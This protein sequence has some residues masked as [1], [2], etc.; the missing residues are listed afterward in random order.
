MT[1][2]RTQG[3]PA[4]AAEFASRASLAGATSYHVYSASDIVN[5]YHAGL[6]N[7]VLV[8]DPVGFSRQFNLKGLVG[9][10]PFNEHP[11]EVLLAHDRSVIQ[12]HFDSITLLPQNRVWDTNYGWV[13][14]VS[15]GL[16]L[17]SSASRN[18]RVCSWSFR[19]RPISASTQETVF[20]VG[21]ISCD[22]VGTSLL[23]YI[24]L[25]SG[26]R[27]SVATLTLTPEQFN[28]VSC[29]QDGPT[30]YIGVNNVEEAAPVDLDY[31][32]ISNVIVV[33][34]SAAYFL[35]SDLKLWNV[36]KTLDELVSVNDYPKAPTNVPFLP[37]FFRSAGKSEKWAFQ[38][39]Q[40]GFCYPV[41]VD[42]VSW[43]P[44]AVIQRYTEEGRYFGDNRFKEVGLGGGQ[45][46]PQSFQFGMRFYEF[47][48]D[49]QAIVSTT[50]SN[51]PGNNALW[52]QQ[53]PVPV[54]I[55]SSSISIDSSI[56]TIDSSGTVVP[57]IPLP[58]EATNP[59]RDRMTVRGVDGFTYEAFID[60]VGLGPFFRARKI[61][62]FRVPP[63]TQGFLE[64]QDLPTGPLVESTV[65]TLELMWDEENGDMV[66]GPG[67]VPFERPP[68]YLYTQS[69]R[70]IKQFGTQ[71]W[72]DPTPE[73]LEIGSPFRH[74]I[75][76]FSFLN[77]GTLV[78]GPHQLN[79]DASVVGH[80]DKDFPGF[81]LQIS[82]GNSEFPAK[83]L[84]N[85]D[86][87][88]SRRTDSIEFFV[89]TPLVGKWVTRID[90]INNLDTPSQGISR[91][92]KIHGYEIRYIQPNVYQVVSNDTIIESPITYS[93][94]GTLPPGGWIASLN[95][96]G[97]YNEWR[98]EADP[99]TRPAIESY[100]STSTLSNVLTGATTNKHEDVILLE[101][102]G[103]IVEP[104]SP[105]ASIATAT[106]QSFVGESETV[107]WIAVGKVT[108]TTARIKAK[109][110]TTLTPLTLRYSTT[111]GLSS[112]V[113]TQHVWPNDHQIVTF[114]LS[115]LAENTQ[116]YFALGGIAQPDTTMIGSFRTFPVGAGSFTFAASS[117]AL[118]GSTSTI[119][120]T[121][122]EQ[123]PLF[124]LHLGNLHTQDVGID[125]EAL[126]RAAYELTYTAQ[127]QE[128]L[129]RT[130]P[131]VYTWDD[132]DFGDDSST[133]AAPAAEAVYREYVPSYYLHAGNS[134]IYHSFA[135]GRV[136]FIIL[137]TR[138]EK[139]GSTLLGSPQ[140]TWLKRQLVDAKEDYDLI[141]IC[142]ST[143]WI[144]NDG[145]DPSDRD[146]S[147]Y[148][149]VDTW[150]EYPVERRE[151]AD[152]MVDNRIDNVAMIC[153]GM[154]ALAADDGT[155]SDYST[156]QTM[157]MPV[158]QVGPLDYTSNQ[159][160]GPYTEGPYPTTATTAHQFGLF[161]VTD[162][163]NSITLA[164]SGRDETNEEQISLSMTV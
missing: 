90:W 30:F 104:Q 8:A 145:V 53:A 24:D 45:I 160:G 1:T 48:A 3:Q 91:D 83:I 97:E 164:F 126:F 54:T 130:R 63:G 13:Y 138:S 120:S 129:Y 94:L 112:V 125:S 65:G 16:V 71:N 86:A 99:L 124:F 12:S 131:Y 134:A 51:L 37:T 56:T 136:F 156:S 25:I 162:N 20:R 32:P 82:V 157:T 105:S 66:L 106:F 78:E 122:V 55:D 52:D 154:K 81:D 59:I 42:S 22:L 67:T 31:G 62:R 113:E 49:G 41:V 108:S 23:V 47:S 33:K 17:T 118:T 92:L 141:I 40:Q 5:L 14:K 46:M 29:R 61:Q 79:L 7:G 109:V 127:Q 80:V 100:Q 158:F 114:D 140:K 6:V 135:C 18:F 152:F 4:I 110:S 68:V 107:I 34:S 115:G 159:L 10:Y 57:P 101:Y 21:P 73:G 2:N 27:C 116:Y 77:E 58:M 89:D 11:E 144:G 39:M 123:D 139:D 35:I 84:E 76:A 163:G 111:F 70:V 26:S 88:G 132:L 85:V 74:D 117:A 64:Y 142:S 143:P 69:A 98:H 75:G 119:F 9:W 121:I 43:T 153:G 155:N 128:A 93:G 103:N 19:L 137:D 146:A 38:T 133:P 28:F 50:H 149:I 44:Y 151:I 161:T 60:D 150:G 15:P 148:S 36:T 87:V 72:I 102:T 147:A 96:L 95:S